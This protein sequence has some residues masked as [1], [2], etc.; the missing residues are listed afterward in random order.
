[1]RNLIISITEIPS[2][3]TG[4]GSNC[5]FLVALLLTLHTWIAELVTA[6]IMVKEACKIER[7][8]LKEPSNK[9][10]LYL[11]AY[12]GIYVMKFNRENS[13]EMNPIIMTKEKKRKLEQHLLIFY[14]V[15]ERASAS[16]HIEQLKNL[17]DHIKYNQKMSDIAFDTYDAVS[18]MNIKK[19]AESMEQNWSLKKS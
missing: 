1:M 4:L 14:M 19:L 15:I 3:G 10:D 6:E 13:V 7:E 8:I 2:H 12:G 9:Q 5:S 16:I 17:N 18:S 11:T